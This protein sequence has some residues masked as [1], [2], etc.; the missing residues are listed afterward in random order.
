MLLST[1]VD[2]VARRRPDHLAVIDGPARLT[3]AELAAARAKVTASLAA[4]GLR[5]GDRLAVLSPNCAE[6]VVTYHAAFLAGVVLVPV[7]TRLAA[8]GIEYVLGHSGAEALVVDHRL[9][10]RL[11]ADGAGI[12][13]GRV[14][15]IGG[16]D[17]T[18]DRLRRGDAT[19]PP[20]RPQAQPGDV[21]AI[22]YTSGTTSRPKG[23]THTH[24]SLWH[25]AANQAWSQEFG[26]GDVHLVSLS[27]AHIAGFGGQLLTAAYAGGTVVLLADPSPASILETVERHRPTYLQMTPAILAETLDA[28]ASPAQLASVRCCLA[29]GDEVPHSTH[30]RFRALTGRNV[31][32][33]CGM[34]ESFSYLMNPP[35]GDQRAGSIGVPAHGTRVR[36]LTPGGTDA[37]A[38][39]VGE[40]AVQSAA[41]MSGYWDDPG[42]T[43]AVLRDGWL[44]TGDMGRVDEDG[45]YFFAARRADMIIRGGSNI[46][47]L[48]V[49][50]VLTAH[51]AV[52]EAAV[53]GVP[54]PV[55][56]QRVAAAVRLHPGAQ[57]T[58]E[59]LLSFA[60]RQL[61][62][63]Q[64]PER[65]EVVDALP[66]NATGKVD[67]HAALRALSGQSGTA[68]A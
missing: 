26:S 37:G 19:P 16:R 10:D 14:W 60:R 38:G 42:K 61:A 56:G 35:F 58:P 33:V 64:T 53:V 52:L 47:P 41:T 24:S 17:A 62:E 13:T 48:E 63:Y 6:L 12:P 36:I 18:F 20:G 45:W 21:A 31:T 32:E 28:V 51:P 9:V 67:R 22:L 4:A 3:Y 5:P 66:H 23:V 7:N 2:A 57:A 54:D 55:F 59:D 11:P 65:L 50:D 15:V 34:T 25:T 29:G 40:L 8:P 43:A 44:H 27:A 46:S 49:E 1:L 39:E 68:G 30:E